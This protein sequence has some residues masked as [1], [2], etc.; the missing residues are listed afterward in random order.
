MFDDLRKDS[1]SSAYFQTPKA[2]E[3]SAPA[4]T[5]ITRAMPRRAQKTALKLPRLTPV[6]RLILAMLLF[7]MVCVSGLMLL[8]LTGKIVPL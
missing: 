5:L 6:Q 3:E 7:A 1:E 4:P 2:E 8:L